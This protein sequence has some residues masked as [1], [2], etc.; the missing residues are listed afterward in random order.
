VF[1][2][3][4]TPSENIPVEEEILTQFLETPYQLDPPLNHL[5]RSEV[6]AIVKKLNP[7]KSPG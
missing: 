2:P 4:P 1:Q 5:L 7:K 6:H 3:N